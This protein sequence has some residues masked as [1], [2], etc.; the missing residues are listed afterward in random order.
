VEEV[1]YI[2]PKVISLTNH[3]R[4]NEHCDPSFLKR[5]ATFCLDKLYLKKNS[6]LAQGSEVGARFTLEVIKLHAALYDRIGQIPADRLEKDEDLKKARR[7]IFADLF[8]YSN[9]DESFSIWNAAGEVYYTRALTPHARSFKDFIGGI[10]RLP[11]NNRVTAAIVVQAL[12]VLKE[13]LDNARVDLSQTTENGRAAL[14]RFQQIHSLVCLV[15]LDGEG[16][17]LPDPDQQKRLNQF[18]VQEFNGQYV[19]SLKSFLL[20]VTSTKERLDLGK[21]LGQGVVVEQKADEIIKIY[22]LWGFDLR[23]VQNKLPSLMTSKAD[24]R[25]DRYGLPFISTIDVDLSRALFA[26]DYHVIDLLSRLAE[27]PIKRG[28]DIKVH[29]AQLTSIKLATL[30]ELSSHVK[31]K[32]ELIGVNLAHFQIAI[33]EG[34]YEEIQPMDPMWWAEHSA[35]FLG[36]TGGAARHLSIKDT[37]TLKKG[38][39]RAALFRGFND[40]SKV[41]APST[42]ALFTGYQEFRERAL[43][44]ELGLTSPD[45]E[46]L[47]RRNPGFYIRID[48]ELSLAR[49]RFINTY[50]N[51]IELF[52]INHFLRSAPQKDLKDMG[53][54]EAEIEMCRRK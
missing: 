44:Q 53:F 12:P 20:W 8:W 27:R 28:A 39:V 46:R 45:L 42:R 52:P 30:V 21:N 1:M 10:T 3:V 43:L 6:D 51:T 11:R 9:Y 49:R 48:Q 2:T 34:R 33:R 15:Y 24:E 23:M 19:Q 40:T 7:D 25:L 38:F 17:R 36:I 37:F 35:I 29:T 4:E 47:A 5:V 22:S 13:F 32:Q 54:S 18:I 26:G 31:A 14:D 16:S 50:Q 41:A